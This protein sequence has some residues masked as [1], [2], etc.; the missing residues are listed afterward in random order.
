MIEQ[1]LVEVGEELRVYAMS[2]GAE[3]YGVASAALYGEHF[4][5]K[6]QPDKFIP[7]ARSVIVIGMAFNKGTLATV[8]NPNA[9][10]LRR[11]AAD[12]VTNQGQIAGVER[13]FSG[14]ENGILDREILWA[15]DMK[16]SRTKHGDPGLVAGWALAVPYN[17]QSISGEPS[18]PV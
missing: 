1:D 5:E 15:G 2:L 8:V 17:R 16:R 4:P 10:G 9:A 6:P 14:E 12:D 18:G 7:D 13:Y 11:K 3:V